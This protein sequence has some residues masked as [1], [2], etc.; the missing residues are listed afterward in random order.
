[1][2]PEQQV[3]EHDI[4]WC[5]GDELDGMCRKCQLYVMKPNCIAET[6][7]W[8]IDNGLERFLEPQ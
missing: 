8:F 6:R 7:R 2:T 3:C 5:P 4:A 1:M